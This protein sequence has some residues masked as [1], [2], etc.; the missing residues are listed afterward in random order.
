MRETFGERAARD[1]IARLRS[2]LE[3]ERRRRE[4]AEAQLDAA[5]GPE[6]RSAILA[7]VALERDRANALLREIRNGGYLGNQEETTA[8]EAHDRML[9]RIDAH[10]AGGKD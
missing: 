1:E 7:P 3:A 8:G 5:T 4:K 2:E 9:A 10:L 6:A